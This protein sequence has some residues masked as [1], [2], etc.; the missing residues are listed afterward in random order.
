M[1][2][3]WALL[4]CSLDCWLGKN[5]EHTHHTKTSYNAGHSI[6]HA[7]GRYTHPPHIH[8]YTLYVVSNKMTL[9]I[10][11]KFT[12]CTQA[13]ANMAAVSQDTSHVI[14]KQHCMYITSVDTQKQATETH[15]YMVCSWYC[16]LTHFL[17]GVLANPFWHGVQLLLLSNTFLHGVNSHFLCTLMST[18]ISK[19]TFQKVSSHFTIWCPWQSSHPVWIHTFCALSCQQTFPKEHFRLPQ[20]LWPLMHKC[21]SSWCKLVFYAQSTGAAISG[22][23]TSHLIY[24]IFN[25]N[26]F[27]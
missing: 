6:K 1:E 18:N 11:A 12:W 10:A 26:Y 9:Q 14:T 2:K 25:N 4:L 22:R 21:V 13:W 15:F 16:W 8:P 7:G 24:L 3:R 19:G 20:L 27:I 23:Y 17:H 5:L